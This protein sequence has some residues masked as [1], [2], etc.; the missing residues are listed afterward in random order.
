MA[1]TETPTRSLPTLHEFFAPGGI[2]A[3][4]PLPYEYRPGQLEMAKAVERALA[5]RRHLIVEAGTG[6]GKTLAY[7]LPA[8]RTG[9]R[10][11][12]STGTKALQDQL[13][14]RDV[15]FLES[16]LGPLRVCYMKGRSNYL[17]RHKLAALRD[18]PILS[19]LE[20]IDQYQ[21]I[22]RWERETETGD[23]SELSG[24]PESSALWHKLDARSDAC[25]GTNCPDY[26]RCFITEMRRRALESDII[27]VNHHLFF[28]DL[29]V[30]QE[31][32]GAPDAGVLPEAAAVVFDEAHELEEVA[33]SYFGLSVSNIRFEELARDTDM[34]LRGKEGADKMPAAT[35]Q[36]RE[37]AR[38][39]FA[40]LPMS[41]DGRQPFTER[42]QFLETSGDLY[43]SVRTSLKLLEAEMDRL[44]G[45]DEAPGLRKRVA[46]L[47]SELEF[48]LESN[49]SNMVY[50]LERRAAFTDRSASS[51]NPQAPSA[52]LAGRGATRS[53]TFL[54]ATPIDVSELLRELVFETIPTVVLTSATLTVQGGFEHVRKRLGL[55]EARELVVPSHFRYGE[56]AL[57]YLPPNMPDPRDPDFPEAAAE[58]IRRVLTLSRGRAFCL[59]TSYAQMRALYERLLPVL[60]FPIL[61]HGTAPRKALLEE[62]RTTPNA[63]LFGT[64]S[65]WQG[66]DVQGEALSCVIIDRL[67]FA[68][69]NDPIVQARMRAIEE[70]GGKPFFDY[71]VPSAVLTLKQG[72]GRL[73]R[74]LEDRGVLVLLDPRIRTQRYGQT[75]LQSLPPYR[76]TTTI[77]DVERFFA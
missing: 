71:Q 72:F 62:F 18:Q 77:T 6:T 45:V 47:R 11:I 19:G 68:V 16:L 65:F 12:I 21:Q 66:V 24:L 40:G 7:L 26:R 54:Q 53:T 23:R 43:M 55:A 33:S 27:I 13:F 60:D 14:F 17:C 22:A 38:M 57:L 70:A 42:E 69:P 44:T 52:G 73:I 74:S 1:S 2:L 5:D 8:L 61:L 34:L 4:S 31:A 32:S 28:A 75:F 35:Q 51:S 64:S 10:V 50:W 41:S 63:V 3:R 48:L 46:R 36:L 25:L 29:S 15:P 58:C 49:Q 37:R 39:F 76:M 59:F 56:Q 9:Q 30:K 20:E 67:P